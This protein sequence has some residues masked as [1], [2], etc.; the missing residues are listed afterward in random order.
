[1]QIF[2]YIW[3]WFVDEF[4]MHSSEEVEIIPSRVNLYSGMHNVDAER[5][6]QF[7]A[8]NRTDIRLENRTD[9][10]TCDLASFSF[11][12]SISRFPRF[13]H[14]KLLSNRRRV[15]LG[16]IVSNRRRA[17]QESRRN[18]N[19]HLLTSEEHVVLP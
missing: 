6:R 12:Y 17:A 19:R 3:F 10:M 1:M 11:F 8:E 7:I 18:Y 4:K 13:F 2:G 16:G 14:F 15:A 5:E 9:S